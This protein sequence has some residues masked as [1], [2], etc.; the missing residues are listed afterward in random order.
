MS[1]WQVSHSSLTL[2]RKC[3]VTVTVVS[4]FAYHI[5]TTSHS[6][7]I[8]TTLYITSLK[9]TDT[10]LFFKCEAI[11]TQPRNSKKCNVS[12]IKSF[13]TEIAGT[14]HLYS[15]RSHKHDNQVSLQIKLIQ[16]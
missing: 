5:Q 11:E 8:A 10:G 13:R 1:A 4:L 3:H 15:F 7:K 16:F 6:A 12:P 2:K 14:V 9:P